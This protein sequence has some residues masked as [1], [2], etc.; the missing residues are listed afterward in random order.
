MKNTFLFKLLRS[1]FITP[2]E[3]KY[4]V[5]NM[6][7]VFQQLRHLS[8][9]RKTFLEY[10]KKF[11]KD[12]YKQILLWFFGVL[13]LPAS[14]FVL[15]TLLRDWILGRIGLFSGLILFLGAFILAGSFRQTMLGI[16][17][18]I[19]RANTRSYNA[20][21]KEREKRIKRTKR[22]KAKEEEAARKKAEE[23]KAATEAIEYDDDEPASIDVEDTEDAD[24]IEDEAGDTDAEEAATQT[25]EPDTDNDEFDYSNDTDEYFLD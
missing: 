7:I 24:D 13:A 12:N 25:P 3:I 11:A 18:E 16:Q 4:F 17:K 9:Y 20:E 2:G 5:Q 8:V 22:K 1:P 21:I 19:K 14:I 6:R 23:E 10:W 15:T